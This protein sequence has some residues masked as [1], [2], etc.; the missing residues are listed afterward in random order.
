[1]SL[2]LCLKIMNRN[3]VNL[4]SIVYVAIWNLLIDEKRYYSRKNTWAEV[5]KQLST[6]LLYNRFLIWSSFPKLSQ[7]IRYP[8]WFIVYVSIW[9]LLD[10]KYTEYCM[11]SFGYQF[12][13]NSIVPSI[14]LRWLHQDAIS[15]MSIYKSIELLRPWFKHKT[16]KHTYHL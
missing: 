10:E 8:L 3:E 5:Q 9:N 4:T 15:V 7:K 12:R 6:I 2:D 11:L 14:V 16:I 13:S 1:M